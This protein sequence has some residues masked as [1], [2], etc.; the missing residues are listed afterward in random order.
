MNFEIL[1]KRRFGI[2]FKP[3]NKPYHGN[4]KKMIELL[5]KDG[6]AY[7]NFQFSILQSFSKTATKEEIIQTESLF[8]KKLGSKVYGL[9][10][11]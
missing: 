8:K 2:L 7:K 10:S 4:N 1:F 3:R 11:N 6:K 9:N 5:G